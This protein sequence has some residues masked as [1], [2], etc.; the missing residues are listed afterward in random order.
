LNPLTPRSVKKENTN[1]NT[2]KKLRKRKATTYE[3]LAMK[4]HLYNRWRKNIET[5]ARFFQLQIS[6]SSLARDSLI[7]SL[8][9]VQSHSITK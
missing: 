2:D 4:R 8:F 6:A 7:A 9:L 1:N 5:V 3:M